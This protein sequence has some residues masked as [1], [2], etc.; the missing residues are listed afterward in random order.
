MVTFLLV[1]IAGFICGC[2][3]LY[4]KLKKEK[5]EKAVLQENLDRL[6]GK[7]IDSKDIK[8]LEFSVDMYIKYAKDLDIYSKDQH[9]YIVTELERIRMQHLSNLD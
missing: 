6:L 1:C 9:E 7:Q 2:A 4:H 8:F 5:K 3:Y